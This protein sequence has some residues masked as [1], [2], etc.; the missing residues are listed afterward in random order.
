MNNRA[1]FFSVFLHPLRNPRQWKIS[2]LSA[3]S[4]WLCDLFPSC[5]LRPRATRQENKSHNPSLE[6]DNSFLILWDKISLKLIYIDDHTILITLRIFTRVSTIDYQLYIY[7]IC[8]SMPSSRGGRLDFQ[9][10]WESGDLSS[11]QLP[12]V[13]GK[14]RGL[15][16]RLE[17]EPIGAQVVS[18]LKS[19][20]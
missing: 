1:I 14:E 16:K 13:W 8:I 4:S 3:F 20:K 18:N 10:L 17:I 11:S 19:L 6:A 2:R 5:V 12:V 9:P 7:E 15:T